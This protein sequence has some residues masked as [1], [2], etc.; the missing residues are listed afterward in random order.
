M[1][2]V[3]VVVRI[4]FKAKSKGVFCKHG[5]AGTVCIRVSTSQQQYLV[6]TDPLALNYRSLVARAVFGLEYI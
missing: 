5:A 4:H 1:S 2:N 3:N 6:R